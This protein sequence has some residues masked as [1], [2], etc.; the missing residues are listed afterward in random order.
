[1]LTL[2]FQAPHPDDLYEGDH[3][4]VAS[5]MSDKIGD[6]Q[7][8]GETNVNGEDKVTYASIYSVLKRQLP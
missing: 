1:M 2:L 6:T 7:Q 3:S 5:K 4:I 8:N